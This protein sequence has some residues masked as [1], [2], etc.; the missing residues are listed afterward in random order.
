RTVAWALQILRSPQERRREDPLRRQAAQA[1]CG[2][3]GRRPPPCGQARGRPGRQTG[4]GRGRPSPQ[5]ANRQGHGPRRHRLA[6]RG[7]A[8]DRPG[9]GG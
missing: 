1:L 6:P 7:R 9:Q 2:Q 3:V 4:Q 8:A 5:R